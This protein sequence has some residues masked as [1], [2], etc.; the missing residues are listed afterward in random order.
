MTPHPGR[1]QGK[2]KKKKR[3]KN[4]QPY[5]VLGEKFRTFARAVW[6]HDL[7]ASFCEHTW[8]SVHVVPSSDMTLQTNERDKGWALGAHV[9]WNKLSSLNTH[10]ATESRASTV[11]PYLTYHE[12]LVPRYRYVGTRVVF[13]FPRVCLVASLP[14]CDTQRPCEWWPTLGLRKRASPVASRFVQ[15][16]QLA[17]RPECSVLVLTNRCFAISKYA[18]CSMT[19]MRR[20]VK[21]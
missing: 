19:S 11:S 7:A 3:R 14:L 13:S 5:L 18:S 17:P 21:A 8:D 10:H 9:P 1:I 12:P 6:L 4:P 2:E 15:Q 16:V 20:F